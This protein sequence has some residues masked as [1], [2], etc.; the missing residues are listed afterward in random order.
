MDSVGNILAERERDRLP[1]GAGIS[2]AVL[3]HVGVAAG[4]LS[5]ALGR[6]IRFVNPRAV[7]VRLMPAGALLGGAAVAVPAQAA[8]EPE[9]PK[10]RI[11]KAVE[12]PPPP[13]S[14]RAVLLPAKEKK[15]PPAPSGR[16]T[17]APKTDPKPE[18]VGGAR[19]AATGPTINTA[20]SGVG[21]GGARLDQADF[22]YPYYL[23]RMILAIGMNWFK[24]AQVVSVKP[25]VRFSVERDGTVSN[26]EIEVSSGL[27]FVDRA[28]LRAVIAASLPPL[29]PEYGGS[30]LGVHLIFD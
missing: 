20:D 26:P 14:S 18:P 5:S 23:E 3:L 8:P 16:T 19:G 9:P 21:I 6:P 17:L 22:Q 11:E 13:P 2:L 7:S 10:P 1:F 25:V 30:R 4:L 15:D 12:P 29:P 28:A 27:P 24:P